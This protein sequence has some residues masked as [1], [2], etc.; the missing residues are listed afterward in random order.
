MI[1][2]ALI[3]CLIAGPAQAGPVFVALLSAGAS[4]GAAFGATALGSF[5]AT[6]IGRILVSVAL[7][8][9]QRSL[10]K[11]PRDPGIQ[12]QATLSGGTN[13]LSLVLGR[14]ATAGVAIAPPMSHG[15]NNNYLV[16]VI[17]L[18]AVPIT[19]LSRVAVDGEYHVLGG[20]PDG[21]GFLPFTGRL[22]G[23]ARIKI[24]DGTQTVA[25]PWLLSTYGS[26]PERPWTSDMIGRGTAYAILEFRYDREVFQGLPQVRF[27]I[28]GVK[29]YDPRADTTVGGSGA[30][31]WATPATW[32]F[33]TNPAVMMYNIRRGLTLPDGSVWG[34]LSAVNLPLSA[35]FAAMNECDV[36]IPLAAGGTEPQFRAGFEVRVS[37]EPAEV[38]EELL[39]SCMGA[40]AETGDT[41]R[42]RVGPPGLPV[43]VM[44]DDD[45]IVTRPQDFDP[46]AGLDE[47]FNAVHASHPAPDALWEATDAPA[48]YDAALE[49]DDGDRRL[50]T[51]LSLPAVPWPVQVQRIM[52]ATLYDGRR[53]RRHVLSLPPEAA[54]LEPL[55]TVSWTSARNGYAAKIFE[56]GQ[57]TD[58][59][60]TLVQVAALREVDPA[61]Y[62]WITANETAVG[63]PSGVVVV[64]G[65]VSVPGW[66][67][68]G[69]AVGDGTTNRRPALV[70]SWTAASLAG[71]RAITWEVRLFGGATIL[72]G[73][74]T[75]VAAGS[76]TIV[77]GILSGV[78]YEA[79]AKPIIDAP[80]V[81]TSWQAATPTTALLVIADLADGAASRRVTAYLQDRSVTS[82][83]AANTSGFLGFEFTA[84][85]YDNT[86]PFALT[87]KNPTSFS[88]SGAVR[89][90]GDFPS[91]CIIRLSQRTIA[92]PGA[93]SFLTDWEIGA[94]RGLSHFS[95]GTI[96]NGVFTATPGFE[97]RLTA[98]I[99]QGHLP[100]WLYDLN[101][102][103]QQVSR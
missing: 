98:Y 25:D 96:G 99:P 19:G 18:S 2:A 91:R 72:R 26:Y 49:A 69:G 78:T 51:E 35:W 45:V 63:V 41:C 84:E 27:E 94:Q 90:Y 61:D 9:L 66:T 10:I 57:I 83:D 11:K 67:V 87:A 88:L 30:Q 103:V 21:D 76:V 100:V 60:L 44:T 6:G 95:I 93:W 34:G 31:R 39:R 3:L 48:L 77:E 42:I 8:A 101:L 92:G 50:V 24:K 102:F 68:T 52:R 23:S 15:D 58:E 38:F 65:A 59:T 37:D 82:F 5:L 74:V 14:Y 79:R 47:T 33:T 89:T 86:P 97:Y 80:S 75:D 56:V 40:V 7:S 71:A 12:T 62:D 36:A 43:H 46:F 1:R 32:T 54:I 29:L 81:W 64:P 17:A 20:A 85:P 16:Y 4:F 28:D 73:D 53:M 13:P 70:L 55:D 22:A